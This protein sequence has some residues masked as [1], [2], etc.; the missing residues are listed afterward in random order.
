MGWLGP[1]PGS[2]LVS[3]GLILAIT[4]KVGRLI[5]PNL[6]MRT[7]GCKQRSGL[8]YITPLAHSKNQGLFPGVCIHIW[9]WPCGKEG[10]RKGVKEGGRE[11]GRNLSIQMSQDCRAQRSALRVRLPPALDCCFCLHISLAGELTTQNVIS[12]VTTRNHGEKPKPAHGSS[13]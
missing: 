12:M 8:L 5:I 13:Y 9:G 6:Y 3:L 7:S 11:G 1:M 2:F 4:L 10:G